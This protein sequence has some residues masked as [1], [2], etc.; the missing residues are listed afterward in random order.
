MVVNSRQSTFIHLSDGQILEVSTHCD[1]LQ[2]VMRF[3]ST[4]VALGAFVAV[5]ASLIARQSDFQSHFPGT[6]LYNS[7]FVTIYTPLVLLVDCAIPCL[8]N[9]DLGSCSAED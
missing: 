3:T 1:P 6:S 5:A 7:S 4:F 9:A 8:K 2:F